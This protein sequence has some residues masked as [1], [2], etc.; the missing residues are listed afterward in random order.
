MTR[1]HNRGTVEDFVGEMLDPST[2]YSLL[3]VCERYGANAE[4]VMEMVQ[5]G[6]VEPV[7][8]RTPQ[9]WRFSCT[10]LLRVGKALRL[11]NDLSLNLPGIAM[12]LELLDEVQSL[13]REVNDLRHQLRRFNFS[14]EEGV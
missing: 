3:E 14:K 7:T 2:T 1:E 10:S 11:Q 8:G 5:F 9:Q 13:R 12:S 4:Y 6:I